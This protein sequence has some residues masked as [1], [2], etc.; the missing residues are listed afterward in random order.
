MVRISGSHPEGP[1][2]IPGMGKYI[3]ITSKY[4]CL[5]IQNHC[6][7]PGSNQGP[8]DLQSK[9]LSTMLSIYTVAF[10][11]F[12]AYHREEAYAILS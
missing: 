8:L 2:S 7:D 9:T 6:R 10:A 12:T 11:F 3:L 1:G 4:Y 5:T